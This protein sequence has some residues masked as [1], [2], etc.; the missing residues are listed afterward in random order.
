MDSTKATLLQQ[1]QKLGG[2]KLGADLGAD[3]GGG[4]FC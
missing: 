2:E 4:R 3:L 1:S